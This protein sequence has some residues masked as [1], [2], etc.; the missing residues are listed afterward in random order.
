MKIHALIAGSLLSTLSYLQSVSAQ[1][2]GPFASAVWMTTCEQSNFFNTSNS[3]TPADAI[4][5]AANNFNNTNFGIHTQNSGTLI[6]RGGEVK[7]FKTALG[8]VCSVN[9]LYRIYPQSSTPG[10]FTTLELP[11]FDDCNV[12]SSQFP[13]GGPCGAGDQKWQRVIPNNAT[14][15]APINLTALSPGNY[16]LELYYEVIG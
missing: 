14:N 13:T 12:S 15:P 5:P 10:A 11:F 7:T 9:L 16:V 8:N 2:F 4:G 1:N 6:F 3:R